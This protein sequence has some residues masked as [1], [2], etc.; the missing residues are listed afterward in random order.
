[1]VPP[2]EITTLIGGPNPLAEGAARRRPV[3]DSYEAAYDNYR[4]KPPLAGLDPAALRA[5]VDFGFAQQDDGTVR[6]KCRPET[7]AA[8]FRM[9]FFNDAFAHLDKVTCPVTVATGRYAQGEM[10]PAGFAPVVA[11]AL[12]DG[13]LVSHPDLGHFGPLEAPATIAADIR[14]ALT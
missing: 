8:V 2:F 12:P 4:S 6:I 9:G 14:H 13:R 5:Y 7:E 1:V 11:D 3:F 10:S